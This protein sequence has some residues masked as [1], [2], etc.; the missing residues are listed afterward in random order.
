MTKSEIKSA[1]D[2]LRNNVHYDGVSTEPLYGLALDDFPYGKYV[3]HE[4]VVNLLHWQCML[5]N[6][7]IDEVELS[8]CIYFLKTKGVRIV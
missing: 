8:D 5:L 2:D 7:T 4:V 3:R 1:V 6:G